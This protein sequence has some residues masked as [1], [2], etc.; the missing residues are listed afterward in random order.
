MNNEKQ[1]TDTWITSLTYNT[2]I[3]YLIHNYFTL[4]NWQI[5]TLM[6]PPFNR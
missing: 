2:L 5:S 6:I 4:L 3:N 1:I